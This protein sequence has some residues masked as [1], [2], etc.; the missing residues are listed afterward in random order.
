MLFL[1]A[2]V[3]AWR[4]LDEQAVCASWI[5]KQHETVAICRLLLARDDIPED[6][7]QRI[8]GNRDVATPPLIEAAVAYPDSPGARV[9]PPARADSDVTVTV[10]VGP[11]RAPPSGR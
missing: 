5:G 9:S 11:D 10:V 3:Y 7:R 8:A 1:G 6:D 2:E 4:A